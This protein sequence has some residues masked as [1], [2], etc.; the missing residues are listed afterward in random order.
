M[1]DAIRLNVSRQAATA[2]L[3]KLIDQA[4][5][6]EARAET[7][8]QA[9]KNVANERGALLLSAEV[10]RMSLYPA[11]SPQLSAE[12]AAIE[13]KQAG[14]VA[15]VRDLDGACRAWYSETVTFLEYLGTGPQ[16]VKRFQRTMSMPNLSDPTE[17]ATW[18][19]ESA[20]RGASNLR[21]VLQT[22][23]MFPDTAP[24]PRPA[25][26]LHVAPQKP[27][28]AVSEVF[29][30]AFV[31]QWGRQ[32]AMVVGLLLL[33]AVLAGLSYVSGV[34]PDWKSLLP[35]LPKSS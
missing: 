33:I 11:V 34:G 18:I 29:G 27:R 25:K 15:S 2:R 20:R 3:T 26:A 17:A 35:F 5:A 14:L 30:N 1:T 21:G 32:I 24:S 28:G 7:E 16:V 23:P 6:L 4:V 8:F 19:S 22:I 13:T 12:L 10:E 9:L 31:E